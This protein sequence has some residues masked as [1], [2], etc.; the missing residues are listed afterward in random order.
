MNEISSEILN[1]WSSL[2]ET[3]KHVV[4]Y[5]LLSL[6]SATDLRTCFDR[7]KSF[8]RLF[9]KHSCHTHTHAH[10]QT[11]RHLLPE[12][13]TQTKNLHKHL[14]QTLSP[15]Y[16]STQ[17]SIAAT[18]EDKIQWWTTA[19]PSHLC[20]TDVWKTT[21]TSVND[22]KDGRNNDKILV[23]DLVSLLIRT[24][25]RLLYDPTRHTICFVCVE[26]RIVFSSK[27]LFSCPGDPGRVGHFFDLLLVIFCSSLLFICNEKNCLQN[28]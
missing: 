7:C 25:R 14:Q 3:E 5:V 10:K 4:M 1:P 23:T 22:D 11:S 27:L 19:N 26:H 12:L 18:Q 8:K 20:P 24:T 28:D 17:P 6:D 9:S 16:H 15:N 21:T 13:L 2:A